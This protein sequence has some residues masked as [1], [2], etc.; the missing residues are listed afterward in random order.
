MTLGNVAA[1]GSLDANAVGSIFVDGMVT[2]TSISLGSSDIAIGADARVG[3]AGVTGT[4]N[5][6][7]ND[8]SR[9]TYIG[10]TGDR[11]GYHLDADEMTRLFGNQV[12][13]FA[14]QL[15]SNNGAFVASAPG[16]LFVPIAR[17][18]SNAAPDE[19]ATAAWRGRGWQ[20]G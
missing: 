11:D 13:V 7:N 20:D 14:P 18:G 2:G 3:M 12:T 16:A 15:A 10:G 4:L 9:T 8:D 5:V 1:T 17:I 6:R 19:I